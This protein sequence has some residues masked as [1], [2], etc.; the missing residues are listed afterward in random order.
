MTFRIEFTVL[1]SS[2]HSDVKLTSDTSHFLLF[3]WSD[4]QWVPL[5]SATNVPNP[6]PIQEL[7]GSNFTP[8]NASLP[9]IYPRGPSESKFPERRQSMS[10]RRKDAPK[11]LDLNNPISNPNN[12]D[13]D[14][15][16]DKPLPTSVF[17]LDTATLGVF[18]SFALPTPARALFDNSNID[19]NQPLGSIM[20][21]LRPDFLGGIDMN[22]DF[23]PP[24]LP[25]Q[26]SRSQVESQ[27]GHSELSLHQHHHWSNIPTFQNDIAASSRII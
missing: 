14:L 4:L 22:I 10:S 20:T 1:A 24:P 27:E 12:L 23:N 17:R 8:R 25:Q 6:P 19:I 2:Q 16:N 21:P 9:S 7:N 5:A 11:P 15:E 3:G 13:L 18:H 26:G